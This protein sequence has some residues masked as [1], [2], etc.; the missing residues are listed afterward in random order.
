MDLMALMSPVNVGTPTHKSTLSIAQLLGHQIDG[1]KMVGSFLIWAHE[2]THRSS[3]PYM[4]LRGGRRHGTSSTNHKRILAVDKPMATKASHGL[5]CS[6]L[7]TSLSCNLTIPTKSV[8]CT[9]EEG[10]HVRG[11]P[12]LHG[13]PGA[14]PTMLTHLYPSPVLQKGAYW[15]RTCSVL[16]DDPTDEDFDTR[17]LSCAP[18]VLQSCVCVCV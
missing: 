13:G 5:I 1:P 18:F 6:Y 2:S 17:N 15:R 9:N 4:L 14:S 16:F 12:S 8:P 10:I 11:R 3:R 7:T